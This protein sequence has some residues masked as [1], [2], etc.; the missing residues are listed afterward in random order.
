MMNADEISRLLG[1]CRTFTQPF[2]SNTITMLEPRLLPGNDDVAPRR[3]DPLLPDNN[4]S[5]HN[6][7]CLQQPK[8][9]N[10]HDGGN[11]ATGGSPAW[12]TLFASD[13]VRRALK[14]LS[15]QDKRSAT[16]LVAD[17]DDDDDDDDDSE[18]E[19]NMDPIEYCRCLASQ[20]PI[21]AKIV[22]DHD[23]KVRERCNIDISNW[24][25]SV[26]AAP[27]TPENARKEAKGVRT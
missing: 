26:A 7:S 10:S 11:H 19:D 23:R 13:A 15:D 20:I 21:Y 14:N 8:Q 1:Y 17:D 24:I 16:R 9:N 5:P 6:D 18:W 22:E 2:Y 4:V 25:E 12:Q 3:S 27:E